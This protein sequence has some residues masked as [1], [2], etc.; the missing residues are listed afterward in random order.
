LTE[1]EVELNSID[2]ADP[3]IA[4][5]HTIP[6]TLQLS[7]SLKMCLQESEIEQAAHGDFI[8]LLD[9]TLQYIGLENWPEAI[10]SYEL[11]GLKHEPLTLVPPIFEVPHAPLE[12]ATF[13]PSFREISPPQLELFDL[14]DAFTS[15]EQR[16][17][18][19]TNR[20]AEQ[21]LDLFVREA[22]ELLGIG[23][24]L[25]GPEKNAKKVLER[26]L[27]SII[28]YKSTGPVS[29]RL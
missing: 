19:L 12:P 1:A 16:L 25:L 26:V 21:D 7:S 23:R 18:Q 6:D 17:A 22:G 13:P 9:S 2:A 20:C 10:K 24:Q 29:S 3:D 15:T 8:K 11:V 4:D 5:M 27:T 14:E 28:Q